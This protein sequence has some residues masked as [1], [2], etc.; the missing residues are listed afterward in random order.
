M[1]IGLLKYISQKFGAPINFWPRHGN[2]Q[3][4]TPDHS[5]CQYWSCLGNNY[6]KKRAELILIFGPGIGREPLIDE[7][8]E[9]ITSLLTVV[10]FIQLTWCLLPA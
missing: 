2:A 4:G 7:I 6:D 8:Y 9:H 3:D 10:F 5:C 1:V